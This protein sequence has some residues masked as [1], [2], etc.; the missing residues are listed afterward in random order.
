MQQVQDQT[1][2]FSG[3]M[4]FTLLCAGFLV[5]ISLHV[6]YNPNLMIRSCTSSC[7]YVGISVFSEDSVTFVY[8][9]FEWI[10]VL[11]VTLINIKNEACDVNYI[12]N[13]DPC[14]TAKNGRVSGRNP[15]FF[16]VNVYKIKPGFGSWPLGSPAALGLRIRLIEH[17]VCLF[18]LS[19]QICLE[20]EFQQMERIDAFLS[21]T[22]HCV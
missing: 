16:Q 13:R 5:V 11:I 18:E 6:K 7:L 2:S 8:L 21:V 17:D 15:G 1:H 20:R 9:Q 3:H 14:F 4:T 12:L 10:N 19:T 22:F